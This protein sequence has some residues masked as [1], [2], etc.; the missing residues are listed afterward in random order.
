MG[1]QGVL[2]GAENAQFWGPSV[3]DQ[4][5]GY[6]VSYIHHLWVARQEVQDPIAHVGVETQGLKLNDVFG[7]YYGVEC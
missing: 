7:G 1:E 6:V 2:E 5:S 3:D 4:R